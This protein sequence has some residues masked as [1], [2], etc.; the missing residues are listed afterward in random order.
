MS[1]QIDLETKVAIIG[2][3]PAGVSTS[4][5]LS[6]DKISHL[7]IDKA[8][9]PRDKICGDGLSGKVVHLLSE[10]DSNFIREMV[11]EQ[12]HFL[13]SWGVEFIAPNG[14]KVAV[15]YEDSPSDQKYPPGFVVR[16]RDFD[17]FLV[18]HLDR[19]FADFREHTELKTII[20]HSDGLYLHLR[21][22]GKDWVC[23]TQ[24]VVGAEGDRS[25]VARQLNGNHTMEPK[26]FM[27]GL[28]TYYA[29][30]QQLHPKNFIELHFLKELTPGYF[31]IFPLPG[32][33]ANVGIALLSSQVRKEK[34]HMRE[35]LLKIINEH[36]ELAPRFNKAERLERI[37]G[38]GLPLG[39]RRRPL[40][41]EG[42]I[43]TGDAAS[44]ID[45][46][47]GEGIGN[48]IL[49]G[50]IAAKVIS[51]AVRENDYSGAFLSEYDQA[52]YRRLWKE[53][54]LG[55]AIRRLASFPWLFNFLFNHLHKNKTLQQTFSAMFNNIDIRA[56]LKSPL[57]YLRLL[58][59]K[60]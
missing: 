4:L 19:N 13:D 36:P 56:Q 39:S 21:S 20:R 12:D 22:D 17:D 51:A 35:L 2:A 27:A 37:S 58:F 40:S 41:G 38:W 34:I 5:F 59:D 26:H 45:P 48:A 23:K 11:D 31:W 32:N 50:R 49:S 7:I 33:K 29:N 16:R 25:V 1:V 44:L 55:V 24:L 42:Y 9:F 57:F 15:E 30:V 3:G 60:N 52:V 54:R 46:F 18:R 14:R 53:L 6:K 43:L 28:R 8:L 10:Y 47:S